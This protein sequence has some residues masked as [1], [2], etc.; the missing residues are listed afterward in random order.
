MVF[1]QNHSP[2]EKWGLRPV[3]DHEAV[4]QNPTLHISG[5]PILPQLGAVSFLVS[6]HL[7]HI[8]E[9]CAHA[10]CATGTH[11]HTHR[12]L[13]FSSQNSLQV[14][15]MSHCIKTWKSDSLIASNQEVDEMEA[16]RKS[17][18]LSSGLDG[19]LIQACVSN[20]AH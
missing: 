4:S 19:Q 16:R 8:S 6:V 2:A 10:T 17:H 9:A 3:S 5:P 11:T 7:A 1:R 20:P 13:F 14:R 15:H 12:A 18:L